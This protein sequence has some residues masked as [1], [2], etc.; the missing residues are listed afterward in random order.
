[1]KIS[2]LVSDLSRNCLARSVP[3]A[4]VLKRNHEVEVIGPAF[5]GELYAPYRDSFPYKALAFDQDWWGTSIRRRIATIPKVLRHVVR[6]TTGDVIYAFKPRLSSFGAGLIARRREK[7]PLILDMEDWDAD[8]YYSA[9]ASQKL[10]KLLELGDPRN[11]HY[12][13]WMEALTDKADHKTVIS[14]FL[15]ERF[16]G[17]L[18][19][20][21]PDCSLFDP[22]HYDG[23]EMRRKLGLESSYLI[24]FTGS[25]VPH[26]GLLDLA[27]AVDR[28][29]DGRTKILVVGPKTEIVAGLMERHSASVCHLEPQPHER[30]PEF[31][32][33]ADLIALPQRDTPFARA[34]VPAKLYEAMAMAKPVIST[35]VSD[36]PVILESCGVVVPPG[37]VS[38]IAEAIEAMRTDPSLSEEIGVAARQKCIESYGWDAMMKVLE[39]VIGRALCSGT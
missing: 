13:R 1:M 37:D 30:M 15:Q 39:K 8:T 2:L 23:R 22:A 4:S 35:T 5:E 3:I 17:V 27:N 25:A 34:Q 24:L 6:E 16:G 19:P 38:A 29:Q 31:L 9:S 20:N 33:A 26:K 36:I 21:G 11:L 10:R 18:L 14:S 32:A 28:V 7:R 12:D